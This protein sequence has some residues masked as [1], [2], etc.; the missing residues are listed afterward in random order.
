MK[1][2]GLD[3]SWTGQVPSAAMRGCAGE[4][5]KTSKPAGISEKVIR[6]LEIYTMIVDVGRLAVSRALRDSGAG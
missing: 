6:L 2:D 4:R 3:S 1:W 5:V